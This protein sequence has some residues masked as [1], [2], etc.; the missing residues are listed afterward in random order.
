MPL[1]GSRRHSRVIPPSSPH[2]PPLPSPLKLSPL[3]LPLSQRWHPPVCRAVLVEVEGQIGGGKS[4]TLCFES[5]DDCEEIVSALDLAKAQAEE[6]GTLTV[7]PR[8]KARADGAVLSAEIF[9]RRFGFI[10][11]MLLDS[12]T[13]PVVAQLCHIQGDTSAA[14]GAGRL[15]AGVLYVTRRCMIAV[16][17]RY[18]ACACE[19]TLLKHAQIFELSSVDDVAMIYYP[20]DVGMEVRMRPREAPG[21]EVPFRHSGRFWFGTKDDVGVKVASKVKSTRPTPL[22]QT[23]PIPKPHLRCPAK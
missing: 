16:P 2:S 3:L 15:V 1:K 21:E 19:K 22:P 14:G 17:Q 5:G 20:S 7:P 9:H 8:V 12:D 13:G 4:L 11:R 18:S 10:L 23:S 6:S